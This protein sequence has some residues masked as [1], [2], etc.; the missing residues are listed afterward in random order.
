MKKAYPIIITKTT[1]DEEPYA[2][3]VPDF[4]VCTQGTDVANAMYMA[5]DAIS[6]CGVNMEDN[7]EKIPEPSNINDID[8]KASPWSEEA[9]IEDEFKTLV[10]VDFDLY[11]KRI[12]NLSVRRNVTLPSWLDAE[13]SRANINVSAV[14]QD[15][16]RKELHI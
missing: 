9:G 14:L 8:I 13:A 7:G 15:A 1:G 10:A 12:R 16:L 4:D 6:L 5:E 11:R 2:V 3:Y